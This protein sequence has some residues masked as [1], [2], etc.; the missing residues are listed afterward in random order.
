MCHRRLHLRRRR[1]RLRLRLR[2]RR[3]LRLL[4][5]RHRHRLVAHPVKR[6][7]GGGRGRCKVLGSSA[8]PARVVV[9]NPA[10]VATPRATRSQ[11][12]AKTTAKS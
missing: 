4:P 8:N 9:V 2:R 11:A 7:R 5:C 10:R 3:R 1:L 12:R 6:W